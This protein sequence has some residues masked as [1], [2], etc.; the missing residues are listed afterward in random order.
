MT[1]E[2]MEAYCLEEG[3]Q[4][5]IGE[6]IYLVNDIDITLERKYLLWL[7]DEEGYRKTLT[8]D[9]SKK[10]PVIIDTLAEV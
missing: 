9:G 3:D 5:L 7:T 2:R 8:V 1:T 6:N 10:L 4:L